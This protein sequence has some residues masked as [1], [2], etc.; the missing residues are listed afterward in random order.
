MT[1]RHSNVLIAAA[2]AVSVAALAGSAFAQA[3]R[4]AGPTATAPRPAAP[5]AAAAAA[6]LPQGPAI[7]GVCVFSRE[8]AIGAS[9]VGKYVV[10]RLQQL[11]GAANA[12]LNAE[13]TSIETDAKALDGQRATLSQDIY[14]QRGLAIQQRAQGLQRKAEIRQREMEATEQ[15]ALGRVGSEI[16]PLVGQVYGQRGCSVLLDQNGVFGANPNM[17]I[18]PD[19]VKLL[20][21]KITQFPFEREHM[22]QAAATPAATQR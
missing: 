4:P 8:Q 22:E 6:T 19:V 13:K 18:T 20:D 16:A 5:A 21:A 14:Q 17:S 10:T 3:A 12:E 2:A 1:I 7:P 11:S 15:K 9:A